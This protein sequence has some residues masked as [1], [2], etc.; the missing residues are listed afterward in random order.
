MPTEDQYDQDVMAA[1][2]QDVP[3]AGTLASAL[4]NALAAKVNMSFAS[5]SARAATL[6]SPVEGM[7]VWLRDVNQKYVYDG[8]AWR[9][10][11][12]GVT[13]SVSD[14]QSSSYDVLSTSYTTT[15]SAGTYA[16]CQ[17][18]FT[19]PVTGR[20]EIK[21][22]ARMINETASNG[23]LIAPQTRT[24]NTPGS[25]S[26]IED[27][28]DGLGPSNYG[29]TFSRHGVSHLLVGLTPGSTYNTR[30]LHKTSFSGATATFALRE[31]IVSP[32]P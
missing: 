26:I 19:A 27:A 14:Q 10:V 16:H 30:L 1:S 13:D 15:A 3:D 20:V 6:T 31:L 2:L 12:L 11:P 22:S 7:E 29:N 8:T 5:A 21:T 28:S 25:G 4:A 17:V 9:Q 24:G 32:A 23:C 18:V